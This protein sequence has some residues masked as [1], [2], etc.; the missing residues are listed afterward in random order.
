MSDKITTFRKQ[1]DNGSKRL[2]ELMDGFSFQPIMPASYHGKEVMASSWG[3]FVEKN[4]D[5]DVRC[6]LTFKKCIETISPPLW[7]TEQIKSKTYITEQLAVY[8]IATF[9][10]RINYACYKHAYKRYGKKINII[11]AIEGGD[12]DLRENSNFDEDKRLHAHLLL[13]LPSHI[14]IDSFTLKVL[15]AW[16]DTPWGYNENK[17][18]MIKTITGSA[19]YNVKSTTDS[20]DLKNT[21]FDNSVLCN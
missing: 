14:D 13:Q 10:E 18:E 1:R 17:I 2:K 8:N 12:M 9:C 5:V 6:D 16:K 20:L 21:Y 3:S 7:G 19:S 11:S 4:V 15:S